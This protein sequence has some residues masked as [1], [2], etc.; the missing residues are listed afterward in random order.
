MFA[1]P[2]KVKLLLFRV[3][4][5]SIQILEL[6]CFCKTC[7]WNFDRDCNKYVDCLGQFQQF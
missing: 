1:E 6:F 7:S 4:C 2:V 3:F 5:G